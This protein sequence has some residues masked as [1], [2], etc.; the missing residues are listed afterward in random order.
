MTVE[1][2]KVLAV[3]DFCG[4]VV[5]LEEAYIDRKGVT[6]CRSYYK[7]TFEDLEREEDNEDD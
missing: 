6:F 5:P 2:P 4:D 3:C 7:G 1:E